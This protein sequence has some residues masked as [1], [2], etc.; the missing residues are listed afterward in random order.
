MEWLLLSGVLYAPVF[1][2]LSLRY[3]ALPLVMIFGLAP[4]QQDMSQSGGL[5]FSLAEIH[6]LLSVPLI[7]RRRAIHGMGWMGG[8]ALTALGCFVVLTLPQWRETSAISL[9]QMGVYWA[10]AVWVCR[11]LPLKEADV[12]WAWRVLVGSS[13]FLAICVCVLGSPYFFGLHKNGVGA[14][15]A[16][17]LIVGVEL[18]SS[19]KRPWAYVP[20]LLLM[21]SGLVLGLSR[22]AWLAAACG[23]CVWMFLRSRMDLLLRMC[24][25]ALPLICAVWIGLSQDSKGYVTG[26]DEG[27]ENIR[28]RL[29][30]VDYALEQWS[31]SP[32][33]G[34]GVG[35][36]K[37]YDATNVVLLTLAE[38]GLLG[39][40]CFLGLHGWILLRTWRCTRSFPIGSTGAAA[41]ALAGAL[42]F[43]KLAHGMV[44]HYWSRGA[45]MLAWGGVGLAL[46]VR[47]SAVFEGADRAKRVQRYP[48]FAELGGNTKRVEGV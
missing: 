44:D 40:G 27:R 34:V 39:V 36:R 37:E 6:L 35:L 30:S 38:S 25:I 20:I 33:L 17:G 21:V 16:I 18:W 47:A 29:E 45:L 7:L 1:W 8:A 43:A 46:R 3:S 4:F 22:G 11:N 14:S 5:H 48:S 19:S 42:V 41:A 28:A 24:A 32:W 13:A 31:R 10:G 26:I 9:L 12:R 23:I 15:I 2:F